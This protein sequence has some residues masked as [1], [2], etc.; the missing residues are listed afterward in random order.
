MEELL[1]ERTAMV[2][3]I[4]KTDRVKPSK[5]VYNA[6]ISKLSQNLRI[7]KKEAKKFVE[8]FIFSITDGLE[9]E[10]D[11]VYIAKMGTFSVVRIKGKIDELSGERVRRADKIKIGFVPS[12][13][14]L[15]YTERDKLDLLNQTSSETKQG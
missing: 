15:T 10:G 8:A 1:Q 7:S 11:Q 3:P 9:I 14:F 12:S 4:I 2:D 5:M 13:S 6:F